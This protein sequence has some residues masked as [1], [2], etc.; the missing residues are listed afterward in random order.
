[1]TKLLK[2]PDKM[3]A[4]QHK[5][6]ESVMDHVAKE[7][8]D[9]VGQLIAL[10]Q[11]NLHL[12]IDSVNTSAQQQLVK[13]VYELVGRVAGELQ[14]LG[15]GLSGTF[16]KEVGL[17]NA[18]RKECAYINDS[19]KLICHLQVPEHIW[20]SAGQQLLVYRIAQEALHNVLK[21]A[22]ASRVNISLICNH[23]YAMLS[24][25][26]NGTGF[27]YSGC[28]PG[29]G[30]VNMRNRARSLHASF[31]LLSAPGAGTT[32]SLTLKHSIYGKQSNQHRN[33][34]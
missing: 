14:S 8:H 21:H 32:I 1:M 15:H 34:R 30:L 10:A 3:L 12:L 27:N 28:S 5:A 29:A 33:S 9:N 2:Y 16:V 4:L 24:V 11:A 22:R 20:L 25:A 19:G 18:L 7:I 23:T 6:Q 13:N 17:I 31:N 26:D